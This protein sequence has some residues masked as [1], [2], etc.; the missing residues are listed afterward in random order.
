MKETEF[1]ALISLLEDDDPTVGNH[2]QGKLLSMGE[3]VIPRLEAA[4]EEIGDSGIQQRLEDIIYLI[5]SSGTLEELHTWLEEDEPSLLKAWFLVSQYQYPELDYEEYRHHIS[6]LINRIWLR[7]RTPMKITDRLGLVRNMLFNDEGFVPNRK[8][9]Y[10][11]QNYLINGFFKHKKGGPIS[12]GLL[13]LILCEELEIPIQGIVLPGYFVLMYRDEK[14]E[15][16]IDVFNKGAL[17]KR[18]DLKRFLKEV[19]ASESSKYYEP[20]SKQD[21][22]FSFIKTLGEISTRKKKMDQAESWK[23]LLNS[24]QNK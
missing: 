7:I 13:Y 9:V 12:L 1:K 21:I 16:F 17:F 22:L 2:I 11:I 15:F 18:D 20:S 24:L 6:R 10:D 5:Q 14:N 4:W 3:E 19:N 23:S 8:R